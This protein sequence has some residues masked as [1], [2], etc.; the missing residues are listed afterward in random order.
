MSRV[1]VSSSVKYLKFIEISR[2]L[3]YPYFADRPLNLRTKS[4]LVD[5][6]RFEL[7]NCESGI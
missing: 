3:H 2:F 5:I 7:Q 6:E 1:R 4:T